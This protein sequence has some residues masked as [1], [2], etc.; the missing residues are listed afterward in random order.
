VHPQQWEYEAGGNEEAGR[1]MEPRHLESCGPQDSPQAVARESRRCAVAG[2]QQF[3]MR[4]GECSGHHRGLRAGHASKGVTRERGRAN[5]FL[6]ENQAKECRP[7]RERLPAWRGGVSLSHE[8][9]ETTGHKES[10]AIQ[11]IGAGEGAPH[12]LERGHGQ[13]AR[14]IVPM[15]GGA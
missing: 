9:L 10:D 13:S 8:P 4:Q 2:R 15:A 3:W 14:L 12:D 11:G 7:S 5:G 6:V 1:V